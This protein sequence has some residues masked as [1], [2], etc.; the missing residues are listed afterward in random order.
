MTWVLPSAIALLIKI[1]LFFYSNT[2]KQSAFFLFISATFCLNFFE[3][4]AF[5]RFDHDVLILKL[6]YCAAVFTALYLLIV[7]SD[8]SKTLSVVSSP[9]VLVAPALLATLILTTDSIIEGASLLPN[10]SITR[11]PGRLYALFQIYILA[12]LLLSITLLIVSTIRSKDLFTRKRSAI[13]LLGFAPFIVLP[14]VLIAL[15]QLGYQVNM[16]GYLSLATCF[17][18]FVFISLSDKHKLFSMMKY[19]PYTRERRFY[20]ELKDI[21]VKL[22]LPS[23]GES[24]DMKELLKEIEELVI[25]NTH[26]YFD[27]QREVARALNVSESTLSR[28]IAKKSQL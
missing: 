21:L 18:L 5:F 7:C 23:T 9:Y 10:H 12:S 2:Q 19:V 15:M 14:M 13:A 16:A 27:T 26:H 22:S 28:R 25:R 11:I 20:C 24:V 8:I 3:L 1:Y 4:L 17:M 6:Y